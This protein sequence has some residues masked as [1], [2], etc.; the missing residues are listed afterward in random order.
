MPA[1]M[2]DSISYSLSPT[3]ER[4]GGCVF[5]RACDRRVRATQALRQA[6]IIRRHSPTVTAIDVSHRTSPTAP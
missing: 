3:I 4:F 5:W 1:M 6:A 2:P